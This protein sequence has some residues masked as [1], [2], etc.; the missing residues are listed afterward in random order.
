MLD[1]SDNDITKWECWWS[2]TESG[3][4]RLDQEDADTEEH[5]RIAVYD[6]YGIPEDDNS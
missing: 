2:D 4:W 3:K 5:A 1:K 6:F